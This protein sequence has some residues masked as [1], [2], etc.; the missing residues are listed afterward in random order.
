MVFLILG[1]FAAGILTLSVMSDQFV[2]AGSRKKIH[3]TQTMTS[4][5]DPAI[6]HEKHQLAMILP[7]NQGSIYDGSMTFS[8]SEPVEIIVLHEINDNDA[9]GQPIWSIDGKTIFALSL[10]D[11]GKKSDSFEFTGSALAL[12][13]P[14]SKEF[15]VT[16]SLDGWIRGE[17]TEVIMQK[18]E[19]EN[20]ESPIPLSRTNIPVTIPMHKGFYNDQLIFYIVTDSSDK[21]FANIISEKQ[22]WKVQTAPPLAKISEKVLQKIYVFTN[23][24]QGDGFYGYQGE[25]FSSIPSQ[26]YEYSALNS[27]IEVTWKK[28]QNIILFESTDDIINAYEGGRVEF[29]ETGIV[30]NTPQIIWP[31]GQMKIRNDNGITDELSFNG[32][33]ITEINKEE[34]TV[35]FV[36]HRGWGQDGR[37][38]YYIIADTTP[39]VPAEI[40]GVIHSPRSSKLISN[41][42]TIDFF[43]FQNGVKGSGSLGFQ[44]GIAATI[45]DDEKYSPIW[46][47]YN[48]EWND[49]NSAKI[50]ES[51]SDIDFF[52]KENK[53]TTSIARPMNNEH[54]VNG[55]FIDPFQ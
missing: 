31:D 28:G 43:Q 22:E 5:Q 20:E 19:F 14:D 8:S 33:Q 54:I 34:M 50:L 10:V 16:V 26:E 6:G 42:T 1:V 24:I 32:G 17:P 53:I 55:P 11:L 23:G 37:T 44:P 2:D 4:T 46:R 49:P 29:N 12:H 40:M 36:A 39:S 30:L 21:E 35:T 51:H 38:I 27:I 41:S 25:I 52:K 7:P 47:V 13:S 9:K 3:F 18:I 15:T 48:V 45:P